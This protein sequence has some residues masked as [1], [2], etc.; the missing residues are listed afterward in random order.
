MGLVFV[1]RHSCLRSSPCYRNDNCSSQSSLVLGTWEFFRFRTISFLNGP[2]IYSMED[3]LAFR[4]LIVGGTGQVGAAVVWALVA[5]PSCAEVVPN[6][7][8]RSFP[9]FLT[10]CAF[11]ET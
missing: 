3:V 2:I 10:E 9:A 4:V 7:G 8:L 5:L 6:T 1:L 11:A